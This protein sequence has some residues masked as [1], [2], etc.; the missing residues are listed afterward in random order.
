MIHISHAFSMGF[1]SWKS[2]LETGPSTA[3]SDYIFRYNLL[4]SL[5]GDH[6]DSTKPINIQIRQ[7]T[8]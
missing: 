3:H 8:A 4:Q 6:M 5:S 2:H 1:D 7:E